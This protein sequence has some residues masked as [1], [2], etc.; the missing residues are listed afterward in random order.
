MS[1]F[2]I[3]VFVSIFVFTV[4]TAAFSAGKT[5]IPIY[6]PGAGGSAYLI[7]GGTA[8][9]LN[10]YIPEVQMM[11]EATGGTGAMSK[12]IAEKAEKGQYAF[13]IGD[14]E[15]FYAAYAGQPPS[16]SLPPLISIPTH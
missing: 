8:T 5:V 15:V 9:V 13:G 4:S 7:G 3:V 10:K 12:L 14:S 6:T 1:S 2:R 11:V 16:A